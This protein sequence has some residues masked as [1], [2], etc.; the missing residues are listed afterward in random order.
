MKIKIVLLLVIPFLMIACTEESEKTNPGDPS[1]V[2]DTTPDSFQFSAQENAELATLYTSDPVAVAGINSATEINIEG[3]EYSV[4][5]AP[6]IA[7]SGTIESGQQT[8]S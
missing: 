7:T 6:F 4:D 8:G 1:A 3:G 5:G 2:V